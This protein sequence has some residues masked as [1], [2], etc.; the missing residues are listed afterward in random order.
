MTKRILKRA[1]EKPKEGTGP[2]RSLK[3]LN[4][5]LAR[6]LLAQDTATTDAKAARAREEVVDLRTRISVKEEEIARSRERE[7]PIMIAA[8]V[9]PRLQ[10]GLRLLSRVQGGTIAEALEWAINLAMRS[11]RIGGGAAETRLNKVV[12]TVWNKPTEPQQI[13]LLN[14]TA[15]ELLDFDQRSTWNLVIRCPDLW[16][17]A[18]WNFVDTA[19]GR[20]DLEECEVGTG[21]PDLDEKLPRFEL[22]EQHWRTIRQTGIALGRAGEIELRYTLAEILDGTAL[23]K[24]GIDLP[25]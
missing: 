12:D 7:K 16:R 17:D 13:H 11:T 19:D 10:Y 1:T 24:A 3:E 2:D 5:D 15:P 4:A 14:T 21:I 22:I 20:S 9:H 6:A 18:S 25:Y 23:K 8:R